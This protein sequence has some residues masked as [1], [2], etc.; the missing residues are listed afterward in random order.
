MFDLRLHVSQF[1]PLY[2]NNRQLHIFYFHY[3]NNE[4]VKNKLVVKSPFP[5]YVIELDECTSSGDQI[6][7]IV[8]HT[9]RGSRRARERKTGI[10][11]NRM[12]GELLDSRFHSTSTRLRNPV[13]PSDYCDPHPRLPR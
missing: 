1:P 2:G 13:P 11:V 12:N 4:I 6:G 3:E 10:E 7:E 8:R 5:L 9:R